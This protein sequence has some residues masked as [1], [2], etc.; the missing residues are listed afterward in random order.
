MNRSSTFESAEP[1]ARESLPIRRPLAWPW[2]FFLCSILLFAVSVSRIVHVW[3]LRWSAL[4]V[5]L[6][7]DVDYLL[8][9]LAG[10]LAALSIFDATAAAARRVA[11][12]LFSRYSEVRRESL[13]RQAAAVMIVI[14]MLPT[15]LWTIPQLNGFVN[16]HRGLIVEVDLIVYLMGLFVGTS[17]SILL[18]QKLWIGLLITP[19]VVLMTLANVLSVYSW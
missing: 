17:W 3:L 13:I 15:L 8:V 7:Q 1:E 19:G 10:E 16:A 4:D 14:G 9:L 5:V 12:I 2:T 6:P 11:R 18:K